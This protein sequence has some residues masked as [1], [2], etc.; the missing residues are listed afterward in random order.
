MRATNDRKLIPAKHLMA[1]HSLRVSHTGE[2][3]Y[4]V[5]VQSPSWR[6]RRGNVFCSNHF[7]RCH[8]GQVKL[9]IVAI[10]AASLPPP[11]L[12]PSPDLHSKTP[13]F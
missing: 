10:V 2:F 9:A 6:G 5:N 7:G 13:H 4:R 11:I 12:R 8:D 1:N 3:T